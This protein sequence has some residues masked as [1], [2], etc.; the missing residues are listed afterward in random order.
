[1]S[2]TDD[3]KLLDRMTKALADVGGIGAVVLGG[4]RARGDATDRSDYDIG[5]YY[6]PAVPLDI[7]ALRAAVATLDDRGADA[8]LTE[9]G[10]W[11]PWINGGGWLVIAGARVDLLYRDLDRVRAVINDCRAGNF[12]CHFQAGHPHAFVS[13][14]YAGEVATCRPLR[15]PAGTM[16]SLKALTAPYPTPLRDALT[17]K[18]LWEAQ[19]AIEN[20]RHGRDRDDTHY[21]GGCCFRAIAS[22]CQVIA[23]QNETW[24]LN[25]KGAVAVSDALGRTPNRFAPRV[26]WLYRAI[27]MGRLTAAL[28]GLQRLLEET[29]ALKNR[30]RPGA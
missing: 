14:I 29:A 25:E 18:F 22:L 5:L 21:V 3:A 17:T 6:E 9:I 1:M 12:T 20:A 2:V 15:D 30:V 7:A 24:L 19:F 16:Q 27:G 23:A 10:G 11:G 26:D 4:S 13:A 28:D 8:E